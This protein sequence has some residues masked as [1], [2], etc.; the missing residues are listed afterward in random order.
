MRNRFGKAFYFAG[1]L[2]YFLISE[3]I[4][5]INYRIFQSV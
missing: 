3:I 5:K 4:L 1:K 2:F